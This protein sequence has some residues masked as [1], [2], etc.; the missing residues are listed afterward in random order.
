MIIIVKAIKKHSRLTR[1]V[2]GWRR[3]A[4]GTEACEGYARESSEAEFGRV[5][6][7]MIEIVWDEEED[8]EEE[9]EEKQ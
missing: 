9:T 8:K 1:Q 5:G 2:S 6:Y 3:T 4:R 7:A